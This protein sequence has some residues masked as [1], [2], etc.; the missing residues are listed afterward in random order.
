[1]VKKDKQDEPVKTKADKLNDLR[2]LLA[3]KEFQEKGGIIGI[4]ADVSY[5]K[6][7]TPFFQ[8]NR[9]AGGGFP[10]TKHTCI[11]GH[12]GTGKTVLVLHTIAYHQAKNPDFVAAFLDV[13]NALDPAW[14]ERLGVDINR[15]AIVTGLEKLE[16][17]LDAYI[18]LA[19]TG[20]IDMMVLDAIGA[21]SPR[22]EIESKG[23]T[24]RSVGDDTQGLQARKYGQFFRMVTP[25]VSR[26]NIASIFL[27]QVYTDINSY[28]GVTMVKGGKAFEHFTHLRLMTR[29]A[30]DK[31]TIKVTMPDG[32][33]KEVEL[34]WDMH[35]RVDKTK[36]STTEGHE[37]VLPFRK[38]AGIVGEEAAI[39]TAI[40]LGLI[41]QTGAWYVWGDH[42]WQGKNAAIAHFKDNG[43]DLEKLSEELTRAVEEETVEIE[44]IYG[45]PATGAPQKD[46]MGLIDPEEMI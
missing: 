18:R 1:M 21:A 11:S 6:L 9:A 26:N 45:G 20:Y 44:K 17:Y 13:E 41:Q 23:G 4:G 28:G 2:K 5:E 43:T 36:Q 30:R 32:Q 38:G 14:M 7:E 19:N 27:A 8:V 35:V 25:A 10:R 29:R 22:G 39:I 15:L 33:V 40:N 12:P 34:G 37:V 16:D 42:K 31:N 24:S 46:P 3:K